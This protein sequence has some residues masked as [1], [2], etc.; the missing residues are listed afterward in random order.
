MDKYLYQKEQEVSVVEDKL[1]KIKQ[2]Y[3]PYKAQEELNLIHDLFPMMKEQLRIADFCKK[4][5]LAFESIKTLFADK[6]L[7]ANTF[8]FFSPEHNK[9]FTAND[10]KIRIEKEPDNP[11][12]LRLNLNGVGILDWF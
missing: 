10:V 2:D 5:G 12:K 11:N 6:G 4:I 7:T 3:E 8:S 1:Q 9:K